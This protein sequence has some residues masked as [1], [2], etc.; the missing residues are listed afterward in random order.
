MRGGE[1]QGTE[2]GLETAAA[3]LGQTLGSA[4]GGFLYNLTNLPEASF[5]VTALIV[6]TGVVASGRLP[7]ILIPLRTNAATPGARG[8]DI[9]APADDMVAEAKTKVRKHPHEPV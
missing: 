3:S 9:E 7:R 5:T 2:I 6:L 1:A 4:M 8:V